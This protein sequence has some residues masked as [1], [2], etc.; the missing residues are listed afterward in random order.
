MFS[1]AEIDYVNSQR[2]CRIA[3]VSQK[4]EPEVSPVGIQF[5][6]KYFYVGSH[7][8]DFFPKTRRYRNITSG[9]NRLSI[10]LDDMVSIEPWRP[11]GIRIQGRAE[12]VDNEGIFCKRK[13]FRITPAVSMSWGLEPNQYDQRSPGNMYSSKRHNK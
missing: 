10:V 3:T 12:V 9:N 5:D 11:R 6:G 1:Q 7:N 4:G 8:P 13:Y 2:V